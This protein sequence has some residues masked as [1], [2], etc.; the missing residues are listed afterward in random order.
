MKKPLWLVLLLAF[1]FLWVGT[2]LFPRIHVWAFAPFLA[3]LFHRVSFLSSLWISALCGLGVDLIC[4][5]YPFGF[6]AI[7]HSI[8]SFLLYG[9]KKHF[10][11]DK[12]LAFS[13]FSALISAFLSLILIFCSFFSLKKA[14]LTL[15]SFFLDLILMSPVDALYAFI[16]FT[17]P[18]TVY[19][20]V[21]RYF[22][23][24]KLSSEE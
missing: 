10:F 2:A 5:E 14:P 21:R 9:Q 22:I 7:T 13:L 3:T 12:P 15:P 8:C 18:S 16:W 23:L 4:S 24:R 17:I 1:S 11:E 19:G 20:Y 6:F